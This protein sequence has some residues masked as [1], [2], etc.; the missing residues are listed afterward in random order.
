[1]SWS[2]ALAIACFVIACAIF[3][4]TAIPQHKPRNRRVKDVLPQPSSGCRRNYIP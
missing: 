1:M 4:F 3:L 2:A